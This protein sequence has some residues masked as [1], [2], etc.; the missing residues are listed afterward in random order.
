MDFQ[1]LLQN[2]KLL[3]AIIGGLVL[4]IVLFIVLTNSGKKE[5]EIPDE[6]VIKVPVEIVSTDNPGKALEIQALLAKKG[7]TVSKSKEGSK[8]SLF[9]KEY[10]MTQRDI[11]LLTIVQSGLIDQNSGLEIFDKGDFT[12]TKD[13]KR[14]R[15]ARAINGELS[16]LIRKISP[17]ENASVFVS[18]PEP[19][20]FSSMKKPLKATVQLTIPTGD[21]ISKDKV[22]AITNLLLGSIQGLKAEN[23]AI[24]DTN[25]NVYSSIIGPEDDMLSRLEENDQ[26]M[27]SKVQSQ[28]DRLVGKGKYV[29]TVSTYLRQTPI[30][31]NSIIYDPN[32]NSV[33]SKQK[34]VENLG[35]K[36]SD[37]NTLS[38]AVS[39]FLPSGL[40]QEVNSNQKRNYLRT[41]EELQY[42]ASRTQ[43]VEHMAPGIIEDISIAVTIESGSMPANMTEKQLK[44][45]V[46]R[47]ASPKV[48][49]KDVEIAYS[50]AVTPF[51]A[52]EKPIH[53]VEPEDSGNPWWTVAILLGGALIV[54][55]IFITGKVRK[56]TSMQESEIQELRERTAMQ[57]NQ[58]N[59]VNQR[60]A[61]LLAQ[62]EQMQQSIT[63]NQATPVSVNLQ[64]TMQNVKENVDDNEE[65]SIH[66][67]HWIEG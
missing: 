4:L 17:I 18:I 63:T 58:L 47:S 29:V 12:S 16:R 66:L 14:I 8:I 48:T 6:K 40:P 43:V 5:N 39:T 53:L 28:L 41:A 21:R 27:K 22:K 38:G 45:L 62:Q 49:Y 19:T 52:V 42:G 37:N 65:I 26:Y 64:E 34:F 50:E 7:I 30:E 56:S 61:L 20:I 57:E 44:E 25:G 32:K 1:K 2:K 23:I 3:A 15:L 51:L 60:A 11:A 24:T 67:K 59:E 36:S 9:L 55:F 54:G 31:K 10:T 33:L 35:D 46:A 13:D